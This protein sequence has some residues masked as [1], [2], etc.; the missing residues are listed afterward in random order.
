MRSV[1]SSI[2]IFATALPVA[3]DKII[4]PSNL[5]RDPQFVKDFVGSYG[6]QSEVEPKVSA[7]E[8]RVLVKLSELFEAGQF[9]AAEQE[10]VRFIKEVEAPSDPEKKPGEISPAMVFVLGNLYFSAERT[11]EARRAFLEAIRRFPKFRRAHVNLGYL[12]VSKEEFDKAMR[13]FQEA[14]SLGEGNPRVF[15]LLGYA[16]LLKKQPLAAENAYRQAYLLDPESKDWQLGLAQALIQQEKLPEATAILGTL[17][18]RYPEDP[19]LWLQ[20][21]NTLL[22]QERKMEAAVNLEILRMKGLAGES[23]LNLLGNLYMDQGEAQL[24]LFAYLAAMDKSSEFD[25]EK[26]LKSAK[27][28]ND[29]GF[30]D[31]AEQYVARVE[32]KAGDNLSKDDR[33]ALQLVEVSIARA[34]GEMEKVGELLKGL[35]KL[36]PSN[37]EVILELGKHYDSLAKAAEDEEKEREYVME[38]KTNLQIASGMDE[39]AYDANLALG[40]LY[41]R[42]RQYLKGMPKLERALELK[43]SEN[44]KSYVAK[45]RRAADR[46]QQREERE[47]A[48]RAAKEAEEKAKE[49]AGDQSK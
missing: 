9:S 13:H 40:Q 25:V 27:I 44:L 15:G 23:E 45:V 39:V 28:L 19:Q 4:P 31:K 41:V 33:V 43:P 21:T 29:Y 24:A 18:E 20:Q 42:E 34:A 22:G 38:A 35:M 3:A 16:Y 14:V 17:I 11:E 6:F 36:D 47:A 8:S 2:L 49:E 30:P 7:E 37:A 46:Q 1:F 26:A 48:D 12:Y 32:A 10:L 5:F